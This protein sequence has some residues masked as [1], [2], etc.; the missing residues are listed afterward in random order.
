MLSTLRSPAVL[1]LALAILDVTSAAPFQG[2]TDVVAA[3]GV[4]QGG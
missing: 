2:E 4:S 1:L 3:Q